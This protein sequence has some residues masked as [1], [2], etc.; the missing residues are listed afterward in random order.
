MI[1]PDIK[2]C[3]R[4]KMELPF[5]SEFFPVHKKCKWGLETACRKC[6]CERAK[7][8][9][10]EERNKLRIE[11]LTKYSKNSF[12]ECQCCGEKLLEFLT[13]DHI[14]GGGIEER[15]KYPASMLFRKLRRDG[16]PSGYRTLCYNCNCSMGRYGY[17]PH[18]NI[19]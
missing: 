7:I 10:L 4:C 16:F 18:Q 11:I 9:N 12:P 1:K 15:K 5:T 6:T 2:Q 13:L 8:I 19:V 14:N 17:C 3:C